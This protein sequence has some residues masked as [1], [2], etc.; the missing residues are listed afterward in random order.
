ME[1]FGVFFFEGRGE[2]AG[3]DSPDAFSHPV[4]PGLV[5]DD[6]VDIFG[7]FVEAVEADL[8]LDKDENENRGGQANRQPGDVDKRENLM[9]LK[10]PQACFKIVSKHMHSSPCYSEANLGRSKSICVDG[11]SRFLV[12]FYFPWMGYGLQNCI[13]PK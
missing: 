2:P 10:I 11:L 12:D 6:P 5:H 4:V 7:L 8:V 1:H 3:S 9:P 13:I